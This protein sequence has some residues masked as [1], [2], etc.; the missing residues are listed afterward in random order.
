VTTEPPFEL[1][2]LGGD[3]A[4]AELVLRGRVYADI[5]GTLRGELAR[6]ADQ[7]LRTLIVDARSLEQIDS[8]GLNEFVQLL[9]R[10]RPLGGKIRFFGLSA[11]ISRVFDITKLGKVMDVVATREA[12]LDGVKA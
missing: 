5:A 4:A 12:A 10:L 8:S 11:N 6:A 3:A 9:K 1:K 7:G 2:R